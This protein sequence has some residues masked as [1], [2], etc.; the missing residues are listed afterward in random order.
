MTIESTDVT[1]TDSV[2]IETTAYNEIPTP[3]EEPEVKYFYTLHELLSRPK[4][5]HRYLL[6]GMLQK[7]GVGFVVG[8]PDGGKSM[9]CRDLCLSIIGKKSNFLGLPMYAEH[10]RAIYVSTEDGDIETQDVLEKMVQGRNLAEEDKQRLEFL[11]SEDVTTKDM[12]RL[13][14][15][16]LEENRVDLIILDAYGDLFDEKDGNSSMAVRK[17]LKRFGK[18]AKQYE[19]LIL[20]IHHVNKSG[21]DDI[22]K[23]IH[24]QGSSAVV[25][26]ARVVVSLTSHPDDYTLKY[27]LVIKG[28]AV[29]QAFKEKAIELRFSKDNF[30]FTPTGIRKD[31]HELS[32]SPTGFAGRRDYSKIFLPEEDVV[33][34]VELQRRTLAMW[35]IDPTTAKQE[36]PKALVKDGDGYANPR[37]PRVQAQ[38][39]AIDEFN[40][41]YA[42]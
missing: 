35:D 3:S 25:Q 2:T 16:K 41:Q 19:C 7:V 32:D 30:S 20:F 40:Q 37:R 8:T 38:A 26:K 13:L 34:L 42:L 29:A 27:S 31:R 23:Q 6:E 11:I 39:I 12:L 18:L 4:P 21:Y 24:V 14:A 17:F 15:A 10:K 28:N 22:P 33:G 36:I 9:L 1:A 5:K